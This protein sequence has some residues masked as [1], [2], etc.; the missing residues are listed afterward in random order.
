MKSQEHLGATGPNGA[1]SLIEL[2]I[3]VAIIAIL[4]AM[5][6]AVLGKAQEKAKDT[7][8]LEALRQRGIGEFADGDEYRRT[9]SGSIEEIR[10]CCREAY[11][12]LVDTGKTDM[13]YT[14][15]R[16]LVTSNA[17]FRAYWYTLINPHA[18][19]EFEFTESSVVVED[20]EGNNFTLNA[21]GNWQDPD[22]DHAVYPVMW[23]YLSSSMADMNNTSL[24]IQ[25]LYTDGGVGTIRYPGE[26]PVTETV[27][28]LSYRF[29]HD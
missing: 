6:A 1:F 2:L 10:R 19:G 15:L 29:L 13:V 24:N 3:C 17:Q 9:C 18:E 23:E 25:V 7:A 4:F 27:A 26:F 28:E 22:Y 5:Y 16:Y 11:W 20:A 14:E 21:V 8:L 12:Q